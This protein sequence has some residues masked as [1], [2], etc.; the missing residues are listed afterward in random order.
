[1]NRKSGRVIKDSLGYEEPY[2]L[3]REDGADRI[4]F[5]KV[6]ENQYLE[7]FAESPKED[8][9]LKSHLFLN[10]LSRRLARLSGIAGS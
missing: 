3:K 4:A 6:N 5:T 9:H 8:G 10:W 2:V 7:L 1:M